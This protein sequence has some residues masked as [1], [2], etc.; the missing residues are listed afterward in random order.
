MHTNVNGMLTDV[1]VCPFNHHYWKR[2]KMSKVSAELNK[3]HRQEFVNAM[4]DANLAFQIRQLRESRNWTQED[5][6]RKVGKKQ[7]TIAQWENPKYGKYTLRSLKSLAVVFDVGL[8][9]RFVSF[10]EFADWVVLPDRLVPLSY[11]K[12]A[13]AGVP[14]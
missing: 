6:A 5:L 11:L 2:E 14:V 3:E 4:V 13:G 7:E 12:E 10:G 1:H 8:L 9:V